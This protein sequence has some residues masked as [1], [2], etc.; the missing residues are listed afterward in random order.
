MK[1][2]I[3]ILLPFLFLLTACASACKPPGQQPQA[4]HKQIK[5]LALSDIIQPSYT[6]T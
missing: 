6:T 4:N 1:A 3:A 2:K 5:Q